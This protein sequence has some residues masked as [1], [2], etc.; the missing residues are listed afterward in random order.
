MFVSLCSGPGSDWNVQHHVCPADVFP[1]SL[2]HFKTLPHLNWVFSGSPTPEVPSVAEELK[3]Q[4]EGPCRGS[5]KHP[6]QRRD[7]VKVFAYL[8]K[9]DILCSGLK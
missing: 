3:V 1:F 2:G 9:T 8:L 6:P 4:I 7:L 5:L